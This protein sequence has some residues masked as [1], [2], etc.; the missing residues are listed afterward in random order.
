MDPNAAPENSHAGLRQ[1]E[2]VRSGG[3]N[4]VHSKK[5]NPSKAQEMAILI[6]GPGTT[7][8]LSSSRCQAYCLL[9]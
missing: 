7:L 4:M 2:V 8:N 3:K 5:Q 9:D 1:K 6:I